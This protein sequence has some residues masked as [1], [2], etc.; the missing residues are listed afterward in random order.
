MGIFDIFSTS[1]Q[2]AAADAEK[3]GLQAGYSQLSD[4]FGEGRSALNTNYT[5]A[6]APLCRHLPHDLGIGL[7]RSHCPNLFVL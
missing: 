7:G 1:D 5:Q 3:A 4:L 2:N 6:L